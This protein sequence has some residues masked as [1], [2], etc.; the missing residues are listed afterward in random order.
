MVCLRAV[1]LVVIA[2][3]AAGMVLGCDGDDGGPVAEHRPV[4]PAAAGTVQT[5]AEVQVEPGEAPHADESEGAGGGTTPTKPDGLQLDLGGGVAM[6][7]VLIPAGEF[8]MGSPDGEE[9]H[10]GDEEQQHRVRITKPFHMGATEV[11]QQQYEAVMGTNPSDAKDAR[12]PVAEV[13]WDDAVAF[14]R[15]LS[16]RTGRELR[17]PTEAQWEYACRAGTTTPFSFG[18]TISTDQANY[19]GDQTYGA[20][21]KGTRR[22]ATTPVGSFPANGWGLCDM[23]GN[24][25][26]WCRDWYGDYPLGTSDDPTGPADGDDR[27]LR[28]GSWPEP[29]MYCRSAFR[30]WGDQTGGGH[31]NGFRVVVEAG[32]S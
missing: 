13:S 6:D 3:V 10:Y 11:T 5:D 32:P 20:G 24:V 2:G 22:A 9:G 12:N 21:R 8:L 19:D 26:E 16:G 23:H 14:C 4:A 7:L 25:R 27:V 31:V 30:F 29:P 17:L 15:E 1:G 18:E 28:G